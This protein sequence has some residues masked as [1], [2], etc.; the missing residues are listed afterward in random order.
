M[1][2][3]GSG[4]V[5]LNSLNMCL[6]RCA[7]DTNQFDNDGTFNTVGLRDTVQLALHVQM[8]V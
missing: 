8:S 4:G 2:G 3:D 1:V 7:P 6:M 5:T